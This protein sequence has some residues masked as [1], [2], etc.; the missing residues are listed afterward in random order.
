MCV[1][2]WVG[3]GG[4]KCHPIEHACTYIMGKNILLLKKKES[5]AQ[6]IKRYTFAQKMFSIKFLY[7]F[8]DTFAQKKK[9][10]AH[11]FDLML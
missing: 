8:L 9:C 3:G 2:V 4:D 7:S 5:F 1:C 6:K 10:V 11:S